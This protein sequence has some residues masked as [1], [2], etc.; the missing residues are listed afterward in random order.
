MN[1]V[2]KAVLVLPGLVLCSMLCS[3]NAA[4]VT[5][6][7]IYKRQ[8]YFQ[9]NDAAPVLKCCPFVIDAIVEATSSNSV[10]SAAVGVS[11][12]PARPLENGFE[13]EFLPLRWVALNCAVFPDQKALDTTWPDGDYT[14]SIFGATDGAITSVLNL[15]GGHY[16]AH[17]PHIKNFG[18]SLTPPSAIPPQHLAMF[19]GHRLTLRC[20]W[21]TRLKF[22]FK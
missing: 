2:R 13:A 9:T 7:A 18:R 21:K 17:P 12:T 11:D 16:P 8:V 14:F 19:P 15:S 6:Y 4:D 22:Q 20:L 3:L 10:S 5:V 1:V